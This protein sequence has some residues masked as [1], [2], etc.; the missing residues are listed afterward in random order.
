M[1]WYQHGAHEIVTRGKTLPHQKT[2]GWREE[3][4][5]TIS[6]T[7]KTAPKLRVRA[8]G[9]GRMHLCTVDVSSSQELSWKH[10]SKPQGPSRE[11]HGQ[12]GTRPSPC[13]QGW[14]W[15][16]GQCWG[17]RAALTSATPGASDTH[18]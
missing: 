10:L 4:G 13:Q 8:A 14:G 12:G 17:F 1:F 9:R 18:F 11:A 2:S 16:D 6:L 15:S 3:V 5:G 7:A